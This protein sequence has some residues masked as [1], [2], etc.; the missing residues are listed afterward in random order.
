M[1][2]CRIGAPHIGGPAGA[3]GDEAD[4]GASGGGSGG[5]SGSFRGDDDGAGKGDGGNYVVFGGAGNDGGFFGFG[6]GGQGPSSLVGHHKLN[7]KVPS[8]A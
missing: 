8:T 5:K 2:R 1:K 3:G 6:A 7:R 4:A